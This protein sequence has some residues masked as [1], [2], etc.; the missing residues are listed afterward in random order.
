M[1]VLVPQLSG[2]DPYS[3]GVAETYSY[4][5]IA[6]DQGRPLY[7]KASYITNLTDLVVSI[8]AGNVDIG[9]VHIQDYNNGLYASI[10]NVGLGGTDSNKGAVRVL[11]Q[12]FES[13]VDNVAIGDANG[14]Q[15]NVNPQFSA[16]NVFT[17]NGISAVSLTNQITSVR[18]T[19]FPTQLT[20]VSL[21]N[22]I[23]AVSVTNLIS[24][25]S[26]TNFPTQLTAVSVTNFPTQLTAVSVTNFPTQLTA[27]SLTNQ[28]TSVSVTNFPTQL[29]AV[30][31]TNLISAVSITNPVTS[32]TVNNPISA[33]DIVACNVTLPVSGSVTLSN[34]LTSTSVTV[35]NPVTTLS[36][37]ILNPSIEISNDIGNA[38]P[39]T[40][41]NTLS[42]TPVG[43]QN[44]TFAD[45]VQI[46]QSSRLRVATPQTQWWYMAS[47]DK[48]GDLR[49]NETFV[50]GASSIYVQNLASVNMT[51]GMTS[52][53]GQ[54]L[55]ASR[56]RHKIIPGLS[57]E[58]I[59]VWNWD[60]QQANTVKR[61]GIFTQFN[62]YFFELSGTNGMNAVVRRRLA[63]GTLV[64]E[65][66]NQSNWNGDKLD[67]TGPSG[68]NWNALTQTAT[69]TAW[70]STTPIAI[71]ND[72][73]VYN[74]VYSLSAGQVQ[75]FRQGTKVTIS[76]VTPSTY[77]AVALV[78]N[79]DTTTNRLTAT[80]LYNPSVSASNVSGATLLQTGYHMEHSC[81]IDFAG[82]RTNRV[83]FGKLSDYGK[84]VLHT[85][86]FDGLLGTAYENAPT[87]TERKEV[88]NIGA[89]TTLPSFTIMG[90]AFNVEA[91][92]DTTPNFNVARN[93]AGI[94]FDTGNEYPILGLALRAG[95]PYQR[96]DLQL[97]TLYI[98][99]IANLDNNN[100]KACF[101]WRV[102]LN[103]SIQG[104]LPSSTNIGKTSRQWAYTTANSVSGGID[105]IGGYGVSQ[106]AE[107]FPTSLNFL[108]MGSNIDNT[109]SDKIIVVAK[110]LNKGTANSNLVATMNFVEAL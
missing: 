14:N 99:D 50:A 82:G 64:E 70:N 81:W 35:L 74:V 54:A 77:N 51:S 33:F 109:D 94:A 107:S 38:V 29:T 91:Q 12:D 19:N 48:D 67:G 15:A 89:V 78:A 97:Q 37:T 21:T 79:T 32:V 53:S 4:I 42:T 90:N 7:A 96:A 68:E 18:V 36:A 62:G 63:D 25:V 73:N 80:Y 87:L 55:R 98:N 3:F 108:N 65:R 46:D 93:D 23:T 59:G 101:S 22:Q 9:S 8:T 44:V 105:L 72:G 20:A 102:V 69:I 110:L 88:F 47:I 28:I 11:T 34:Q 104:T 92:V 45:S 49:Y 60:G 61:I 85:F 13:T 1:A 71:Q 39:V 31:V 27:V 56:R 75:N 6:N 103:P 43:T 84:I 26:V 58:Y 30:S 5:P 24:A 10:A 40:I 76:G 17:V 100:N 106:L 83:R 66:V 16:L 57:H 95:E 41:T 2:A 86:R 52:V